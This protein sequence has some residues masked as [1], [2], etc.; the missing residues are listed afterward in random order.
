MIRIVEA[1]EEDHEQVL[2][3]V[4]QLLVELEDHPGEFETIDRPKVLRELA[5]AGSRYTAFLALDP[6][7][8]VVGVT[9]VMESFAIY[10]GGNY[11]VIDEMYV[12]PGQRSRGTGKLLIDAVKEHGRRKGWLRIEV[13]A[14]PE[15]KWNRTVKFYEDQQF[16]FTGPKLRFR[17]KGAS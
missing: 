11:G 16:V 9:T 14:P 6:A 2:S 8:R 3:L 12:V 5:E 13:T 7:G 17:L 1:S 15:D 10:A 4:E